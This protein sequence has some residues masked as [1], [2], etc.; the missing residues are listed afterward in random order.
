MGKT[1]R[2]ENN[3]PYEDRENDR[4]PRGKARGEKA[5]SIQSWDKDETG[6][7]SRQEGGCLPRIIATLLARYI[8][9]RVVVRETGKSRLP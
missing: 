3:F 5:L 9:G 1:V 8:S 4:Y 2:R 6:L 7:W